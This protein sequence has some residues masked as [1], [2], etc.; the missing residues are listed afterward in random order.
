MGTVDASNRRPDLVLAGSVGWKGADL[1]GICTGPVVDRQGE[2]RARRLGHLP[3]PDGR[4]PR[5]EATGRPGCTGAGRRNAAADR[6][7]A[8]LRG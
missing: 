7:L 2:P 5:L 1:S 8:I 6:K 3:G 4:R